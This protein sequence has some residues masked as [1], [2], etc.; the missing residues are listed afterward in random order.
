ML[1]KYWTLLLFAMLVVAF[2][3]SGRGTMILPFVMAQSVGYAILVFMVIYLVLAVVEWTAG[4]DI[5]ITKA[6]QE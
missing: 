1:N 3:V 5:G 6:Q 2:T 4:I